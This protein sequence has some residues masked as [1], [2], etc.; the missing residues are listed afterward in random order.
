MPD[1]SDPGMVTHSWRNL[2]RDLVAAVIA[3]AAGES[4]FGL[5][6]AL[7]EEDVSVLEVREMP[8]TK[9]RL[10]FKSALLG[11]RYIFSVPPHHAALFHMGATDIQTVFVKLLCF[12]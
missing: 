4:S 12:L 9:G 6:A 8:G 5:V 1:P 2:F 10:Q 7:L 11:L 3:D